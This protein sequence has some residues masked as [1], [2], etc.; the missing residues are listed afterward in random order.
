ML[1][2]VFYI[3]AL[4]TQVT[5]KTEGKISHVALLLQ[6]LSMLSK[7]YTQIQSRNKGNYIIFNLVTS[8]IYLT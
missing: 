3:V 2:K 4:L 7:S 1:R 5:T 6:V 8:S